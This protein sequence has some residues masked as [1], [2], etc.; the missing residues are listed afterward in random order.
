VITLEKAAPI[1]VNVLETSIE[2]TPEK[3]KKLEQIKHVI[4]TLYSDLFQKLKTNI[5]SYNQTNETK[6]HLLSLY[7]FLDTLKSIITIQ[8]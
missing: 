4:T 3:L 8:P 1:R 5:R 2:M 7:H 6:D